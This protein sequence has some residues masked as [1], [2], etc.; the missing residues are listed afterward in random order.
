VKFLTTIIFEIL[1]SCTNIIFKNNYCLNKHY[2]FEKPIFAPRHTPKPPST[3]PPD[4]M[5]K[6]MELQKQMDDLTAQLMAAPSVEN[7]GERSSV[8]RQLPPVS[9]AAVAAKKHQPPWS[10]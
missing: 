6:M 4:V 2:F 1:I 10:R 3:P 5:K 8:K 9:K 7:D